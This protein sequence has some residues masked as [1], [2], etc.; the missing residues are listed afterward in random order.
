MGVDAVDLRILATMGYVPW[1]PT[2]RDPDRLRPSSLA[3]ELDRTPETI[4]ERLADMEEAGVIHS[5]EAYPN[6][7]HFDLQAGGWAFSPP[8]RDVVDAALE[9]ILLVD[10]VLEVFTYRGPFVGVALAYA[11][12]AQRDR[13]LSLVARRLEDTEPVHLL[14]PPM[15]EVDREL[16][17]T[18]RRIVQALRGQARRP[19][20]EVAEEVGCSYRTAKRR[21]D[22]MTA[23]GSLFVVPRV[24][25]SH[26]SG[27]LPFTLALRVE[28]AP[29]EVA[30][31]L[32]EVLG[33]RLLHRLV[34]PDPEAELLVVG[35]WADTIHE[36]EAF[37]DEVGDLEGVETVRALLS[38]GR[39]DTDWLDE[40]L[41]IDPAKA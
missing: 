5:W 1:G 13:R 10:G 28:V 15:P 8:S 34:P 11:D 37:E 41:E 26:V 4:R 24:D 23:E 22:R 32:D 38:A 14:D 12:E 30:N 16:D 31:R 3:D 18:D 40:R 29:A 33:D 7:R 27:V 19:L 21:F 9:E 39:H 6:P 36:M 35:A 2:A 20:S 25:L 17:R